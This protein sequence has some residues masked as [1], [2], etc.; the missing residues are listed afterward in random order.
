MFDKKT[1]RLHFERAADTYDASAVLQKEVANRL[2]GRLDYIKHSPKTVLDVGSGTGFITQDLLKR[3]PKS[4]IVAL[5]LAHSMASKSQQLGGWFRKPLAVCADAE[6]L[7]LKADSIDLI[8]SSL[9]LQ[10]SNDLKQTFAGFHSVLAPNGLLLFSTLG[11]ETLREMRESWATVDNV[12]H[13]SHFL[14]MHEIGDALLQSGFINPV[15]DMEMITMTYTNVRQIMRDIKQIGANN[16]HSG[17]SK[18]LMGKQKLKAFETAYEQFKTDEGLYPATWEVIYGHAWVGEGLK[19]DNY[20]H[21]IPI[22][23]V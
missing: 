17:R 10:W 20:D 2:S 16:S 13:T 23:K 4:S 9:M 8:I 5:D 12:P 7:P 15:T 3:Y 11:P 1:T 21:F 19:L 18:G 22:Q 14:D 6:Q